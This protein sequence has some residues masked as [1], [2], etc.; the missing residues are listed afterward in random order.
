MFMRVL[1]VWALSILVVVSCARP[2]PR[3]MPEPTPSAYARSEW[4]HWVDEDR[5]CQSTRTEVLVAEATGPVEF[6]TERE[7]RVVSGTWVGPY[8]EETFTN[9]R[10]LDVDHLVP[11]RHAHYAGGWKWDR[12]RKRDFANDLSDPGH[13][14]AVS[15]R[16]NRQKGA[17]GPDEWKPPAESAWCWYGRSWIAVKERWDLR[18]TE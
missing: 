13:L 10:E 14:V 2:E 15:A 6:A 1:R 12:D 17:K 4:R 18:V 8:G 5:D 7:C 3:S 11:L 9:P 16:L